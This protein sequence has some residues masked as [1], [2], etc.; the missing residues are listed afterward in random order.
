MNFNECIKAVGVSEYPAYMPKIYEMLERSGE[1]DSLFLVSEER[2][3]RINDK[4]KILENASR[5]ALTASV[6]ALQSRPE[7]I[8]YVNVMAEALCDRDLIHK[9]G[10][11]EIPEPSREDIALNFLAFVAMLPALENADKVMHERKFPEEVICANYKNFEY[12][13]DTHFSRFD[14]YAL[15]DNYFGWLQR[16]LDCIIMEYAGYRFEMVRSYMKRIIILRNTGSGEYAYV[17]PAI[18]M[19]RD[20]AVL[21]SADFEDEDGAYLA[22]F[23]EADDRFEGYPCDKSGFCTGKRVIYPRPEWELYMNYD[24]PVI[25]THFPK[26]SNLKGTAFSDACRDAIKLFEVSYPEFKPRA[27]V[28]CSWLL[29]PRVD[30]VCGGA[31]NIVNFQSQFQIFPIKDRGQ[32]VFKFVFLKP[33]DSYEELP[34]DTRLMRG[35][36][37]RYIEG[38]HILDF[39]GIFPIR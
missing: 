30:E 25:N 18:M 10:L 37:K 7:L 20:G 12:C 27:F 3:L 9:E 5:D 33:F 22:E 35:I 29:D 32:D 31:P 14:F 2:V 38:K 6:H 28:C 19:H 24:G 8:R 1:L 13:V 15:S 17:M 23:V 16:Y 21:G 11:P 26:G 4:Y 36:K 34:E 39:G